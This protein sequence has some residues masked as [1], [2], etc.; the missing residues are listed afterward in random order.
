MVQNTSKARQTFIKLNQMFI[1]VLVFYY[2]NPK[3]QIC[4][5][6]D[7]FGCIISKVS[8]QLISDYFS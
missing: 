6:T 4:I 5:K 8:N 3:R 2:Y 1:K 7:V